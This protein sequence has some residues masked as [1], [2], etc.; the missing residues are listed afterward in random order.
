MSHVVRIASS[1][2]MQSATY[3]TWKATMSTIAALSV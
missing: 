2:Y 3:R 1:W